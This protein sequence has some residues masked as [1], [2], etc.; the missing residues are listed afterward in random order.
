MTDIHCQHCNRFLGSYETGSITITL[1][2]PNCK[3]LT[4]YHYVNLSEYQ[5]KRAIIGGSTEAHS[6]SVRN[7]NHIHTKEQV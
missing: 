2:C 7:K 1:K 4:R 6:K 3:Q 5:P